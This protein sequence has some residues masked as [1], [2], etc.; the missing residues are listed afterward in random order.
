MKCSS[1]VQYC[2]LCRLILVNKE[3]RNQQVVNVLTM[4]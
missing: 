1:A 4:K 3:M 2:V